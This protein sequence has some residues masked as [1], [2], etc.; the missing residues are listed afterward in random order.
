MTNEEIDFQT[1]KVYESYPRHVAPRAALKAIQ[2]AVERLV[3]SKACPDQLEARRYLYK[4]A[5]FYARSP[6][7]QKPP[8]PE[9]FRPHPATWFNQERYFDDP[10]EWQKPNGASNGKQIGTKADRTVDA[11]RAAVS[12]AADHSRARDTS[13]DEGRRVQPSDADSLFGRTIEGTV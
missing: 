5:T 1:R 13:V 12:Q 9:D 7:G 3:K 6:A 11:V 8:G 2:K 10:A 4:Q